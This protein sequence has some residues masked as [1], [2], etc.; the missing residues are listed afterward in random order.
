MGLHTVGP[1]CEKLIKHGLDSK[2]PA[3]LIE[4]GTTQNQRV[5]IGDLTSLADLVVQNKVK[6]PTLIIVGNVVKLHDKLKWFEPAGE[7]TRDYPTAGK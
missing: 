7:K 5:H 2:T 1:L 6:P 4:Q 3:A